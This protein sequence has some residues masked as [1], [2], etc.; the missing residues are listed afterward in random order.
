MSSVWG[1]LENSDAL[2]KNIVSTVWHSGKVK[3]RG[4]VKRSGRGEEGEHRAWIFRAVK[5]FCMVHNDGHT[6]LYIC[7]NPLK[8][9][10]QP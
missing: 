10:E 7:Q 3:T 8:I 5:L 4:T 6:P 9:Q 1:S 2:L